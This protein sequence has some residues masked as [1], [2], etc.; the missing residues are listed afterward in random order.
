MRLIIDD[1]LRE[2]YLI[3]LEIRPDIKDKI[4]EFDKPKNLQL[5]LSMFPCYRTIINKITETYF[6]MPRVRI[7]KFTFFTYF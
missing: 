4:G 5:S 6:S 3:V 2:I 1:L 7:D